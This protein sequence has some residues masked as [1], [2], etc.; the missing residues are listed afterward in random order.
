MTIDGKT[1]CAFKVQVRE[2]EA[3]LER[4]QR[5][6]DMMTAMEECL[7]KEI[8]NSW[9]SRIGMFPL[10]HDMVCDFLQEYIRESDHFRKVLEYTKEYLTDYKTVLQEY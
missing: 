8:D 6:I 10:R 4:F 2:I 3:L 7:S 5:L 9:N 1:F